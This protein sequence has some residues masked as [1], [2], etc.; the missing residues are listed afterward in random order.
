VTAVT[1][2][3]SSTR[4]PEVARLRRLAEFPRRHGNVLTNVSQ[5]RTTNTKPD[6]VRTTALH[7]S[8]HCIYETLCPGSPGQRVFSRPH[9]IAVIARVAICAAAGGHVAIPPRFRPDS[10]VMSPSADAPRARQSR[11]SGGRGIARHGV[12]AHTPAS[13]AASTRRSFRRRKVPPV[14]PHMAIA[15]RQVHRAGTPVGVRFVI[16]RFPGVSR[17]RRETPD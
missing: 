10:A 5:C 9:P 15:C 14:A 16:R 7:L 1:L 8:S 3:G 6:T 13:G 12:P 17:L 2:E 11:H 4:S